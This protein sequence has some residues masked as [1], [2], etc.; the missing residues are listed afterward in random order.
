MRACI[1]NLDLGLTGPAISS[2]MSHQD[3]QYGGAGRRGASV[4][5]ACFAP[6]KSLSIIVSAVHFLY[7]PDKRLPCHMPIDCVFRPQ[8]LGDADT[9][10]SRKVCTG[11]A[12]HLFRRPK[13]T[14]LSAAVRDV[15]QA[16]S[17]PALQTGGVPEIPSNLL[18]SQDSGVSGIASRFDGYLDAHMEVNR[19]RRGIRC[20]AS[21]LLLVSIMQVNWALARLAL[22]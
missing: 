7:I 4:L 20:L 10:A 9:L 1:Y 14:A 15:T 13:A 2:P 8:I 19:P 21:C 18:R 6:P 5:D 17:T 3:A 12:M 16:G 11:A 22:S